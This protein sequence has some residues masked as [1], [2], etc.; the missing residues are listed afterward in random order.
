MA[1]AMKSVEMKDRRD[2]SLVNTLMDAKINDARKVLKKTRNEDW[3]LR[4]LM[5]AKHKKEDFNK[6]IRKAKKSAKQVRNKQEK[7]HADKKTH[8]ESV[9]E[10]KAKKHEE[11][12]EVPEDIKRYESLSIFKKDTNNNELKKEIKESNREVL[13]VDVTLSE[14]EKEVLRLPAKFTTHKVLTVENMDEAIEIAH[15]KVRYDSMEETRPKAKEDENPDDV[16]VELTETEKDTIRDEMARPRLAFDDS[17][18]TLHLGGK[19]VT[20]YRQ[21]SKV[22]LPG[23]LGPVPEANMA[24]RKAKYL[25]VFQDHLD[26]NCRKGC[27]EQNLSK[28]QQAGLKS[29]QKRIKEGDLVVLQTDKTGSFAACSPQAYRDMGLEHVGNHKEISWDKAAAT[30][31]TLNG[32]TSMWIKMAGL[33][34]ELG[35]VDRMRETFLNK[36][37]QVPPMY[38]LL[39]DQKKVPEGSLPKT[40][41]V[42]SGCKGM[43]LHLNDIVSDILEPLAR[44]MEGNEEF[45]S[46]EDALAFVDALNND[47]KNKELTKAQV[48]AVLTASDAEALYPSLDAY[49][50]AKVVR[51]EVAKMDFN[52]DGFNWKEMAR[53]LAMTSEGWQWRQW[54]VRDLIPWR[55]YSKG[56]SP[57]IT[58]SGPLGK[59]IEDENKWIFPDRDP[60][61]VQLRLLL[62]ACLGIAVETIFRLHTYRFGG[63]L[64][65]QVSGGP[66]GLR[67]TAVVA[68]IRMIRWMRELK[69]TLTTNGVDPML[70]GF[71]VDDVRLVTPQIPPGVRWSKEAHQFQF[72]THWMEE[73]LDS[74]TPAGERT[75]LQLLQVMN[76]LAPDL[77][78]TLELPRDFSSGRIPTLDSEWWLEL[79]GDTQSLKYS[80]YQKPTACPY[81]VLE[82]SA[83]SWK[84]KHCTLAQ[85]L[86]RRSSNMS[87]SLPLAERLEV[88]EKFISKMKDSGYNRV[89]ARQITISGL[90]GY[91]ARRKRELEVGTP[92]HR[93]KH[94][95]QEGRDLRKMIE[96]QS[97]YKNRTGSDQA[98]TPNSATPG[99]SHRH[100]TRPQHTSKEPVAV[101]FIPRTP[102]GTLITRL[103]EVEAKLAEFNNKPIRLVEEAGVK[104]LESLCQGDPWENTPCG[105]GECTTCPASWGRPGTCR[106]R[107]I[108]YQNICIPCKDAEKS[109]RYIGESARTMYE[110]GQE[111]AED[112]KNP[113]KLSHMRDHVEQCHQELSEVLQRDPG[114]I[115]SMQLIKPARS[116]LSRQLREAVEIANNITGGVLLNSKEEFNRCLIPSIQVLGAWRKQDTPTSDEHQLEKEESESLSTRHQK[117]CNKIPTTEVRKKKRPKLQ[118]IREILVAGRRQEP[119]PGEA[120][121]VE[122]RVM[123]HAGEDQVQDQ[124]KQ[125][126]LEVAEVVLDTAG[127]PTVEP[128]NDSQAAD[129]PHVREVLDGA[130]A[131]TVEP[132]VQVQAVNEVKEESGLVKVQV[133]QKVLDGGGAPTVEPRGTSQAS[134]VRVQEVPN[135]VRAPTVEPR[136]TSQVPDTPDADQEVLNGAGAPT[137]E[138]CVQVLVV[139]QVLARVGAPTVEPCVRN[140]VLDTPGDD[141]GVSDGA[142]APTVE[143]RV[144]QVVTQPL[145]IDTQQVSHDDTRPVYVGIVDASCGSSIST[146]VSKSTSKSSSDP[147]YGRTH[148]QTGEKVVSRNEVT[149]NERTN[150]QTSEMVV[151]RSEVTQFED[152]KTENMVKKERKT[153]RSV[154]EGVTGNHIF[155]CISSRGKQFRN[156]DIHSKMVKSSKINNGGRR[157]GRTC[158]G[159]STQLGGRSDI[160]TYLEPSSA[161]T[162]LSIYNNQFPGDNYTHIGVVLEKDEDGFEIVNYPT[163]I[164]Q[165]S[166]LFSLNIFYDYQDFSQDDLRDISKTYLGIY[167][168]DL[169]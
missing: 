164:D 51:E 22:H 113:S 55:R 117:R 118:D 120:P 84:N 52:M 43:N 26:K 110:R 134:L 32:H 150:T 2:E 5:L 44:N 48:E 148:A 49:E 82:N 4:K 166:S 37:V 38:L 137:V 93:R 73:D 106:V 129:I 75:S 13:S 89:Q 77:T 130:G 62:A 25:E 23:P 126:T 105:R 152:L 39:K 111:H 36:S 135:G 21:N 104:L 161:S 19:R 151:S 159:K 78:F 138:P 132:R 88:V 42:V 149:R 122:P 142:G 71:Y 98:K 139:Q 97:W 114:K 8:L 3:K 9:K 168:E 154:S 96:K 29:L 58:G 131:P 7:K 119:K 30:Q 45:I 145:K 141:Q 127:A 86:V 69:D 50:C 53:Y 16:E 123:S 108:I 165:G 54:C 11:K 155:K 160:R 167:K 169:G 35:Q 125:V 17:T 68:K 99:G 90:K 79:E 14:E 41:P 92:V 6:M 65:E 46:T 157:G 112:A 27:Q 147:M 66:I 163:N 28:S 85:E 140:P 34:Q 102:D 56:P 64:W 103:R 72:N 20:D 60:G 47:F 143:P 18:R 76:S 31:R 12:I 101:M 57:G 100:S 83:W 74:N 116:A 87:E 10:A 153:A 24:L 124:V 95:T 15:A 40:R 63:S 115:F 121:T 70:A 59:D 156:V 128:R 109:T 158:R 91:E 144:T 146:C 81:L 33:G 107:N 61:P 133:P 136:A 67:V 162:N 1:G 80:F 94:T